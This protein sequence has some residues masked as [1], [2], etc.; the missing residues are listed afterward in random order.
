MKGSIKELLNAL[1]VLQLSHIRLIILLH[2]GPH[3]VHVSS[4]LEGSLILVSLVIKFNQVEVKEWV[5]SVFLYLLN[6]RVSEIDRISY[7]RD[8]RV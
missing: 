5:S 3:E 6:L 4:K 7:H 1:H 2:D 8:L